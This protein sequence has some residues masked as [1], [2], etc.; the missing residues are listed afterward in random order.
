M[1]DI[2][3]VCI[4]SDRDRREGVVMATRARLCVY[5]YVCVCIR[6]CK[7]SVEPAAACQQNRAEQAD[8]ILVLASTGLEEPPSI[9]THHPPQCILHGNS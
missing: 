8:G 1:S 5:L 3:R 6:V 4:R 7:K 2:V 9:L